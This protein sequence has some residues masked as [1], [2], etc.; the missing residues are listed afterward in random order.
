MRH[1]HGSH[2]L[3]RGVPL[4]TV[5]ERLGH[6]DPAFTARVYAHVLRGQAQAAQA[7]SAMLQAVRPSPDHPAGEADRAPAIEKSGATAREP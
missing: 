1:G 7:V 2:L 3:E 6:R 5:S 4:R